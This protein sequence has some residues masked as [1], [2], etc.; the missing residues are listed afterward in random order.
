MER[1]LQLVD[2]K[3]MSYD[4]LITYLRELSNGELVDEMQGIC[5]ASRE[6]SERLYTALEQ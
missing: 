6:Q 4:F 5:K 1:K 2:K 3:Q